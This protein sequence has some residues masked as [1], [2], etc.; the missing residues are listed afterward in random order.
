MTALQVEQSTK[1]NPEFHRWNVCEFGSTEILKMGC[2]L[3]F[4]KNKRAKPS[5]KSFSWG[6]IWD[7]C[8]YSWKDVLP[9]S[10][11]RI[12]FTKMFQNRFSNKKKFFL[13]V[14]FKEIIFCD[15]LSK[16]FFKVL[17]LFL[18][19]KKIEIETL[20]YSSSLFQCQKLDLKSGKLPNKYVGGIHVLT[21]LNSNSSQHHW[22]ADN[23]HCPFLLFS[24]YFSGEHLYPSLEECLRIF[25]QERINN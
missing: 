24:P 23:I 7:L 1:H 12:K 13:V 15:S 4:L 5:G 2:S 17:F 14:T 3:R 16:C 8:A 20:L 9:N 25:K 18:Y 11:E 22:R 21:L 19:I 10:V 6:R